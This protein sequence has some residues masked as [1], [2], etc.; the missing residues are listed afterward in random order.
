MLASLSVLSLD[1]EALS[2]HLAEAARRNPAITFRPPQFS[3]GTSQDFDAVSLLA[4]DK[5]SLLA[6]VSR[7]IDLTFSDREEHRIAMGFAAHLEPTGWLASG[8]ETIAAE[9]SVDPGRADLVLTRLQSIEPIGLFARSLGECLRLQ[10]ADQGIL[11]WDLDVLL[12]HLPMVGDKRFAELAELCD[13]HASDIPD[14]LRPLR[15]LDPK[16]GLRFAAVDPPVFPPDL[17]ARMVNGSW[18]VDLN[19]STLPTV[20]VH[21]ERVPTTGS[22]EACVFRK[23]ALAEARALV[24]SV[25]RRG[26]TLLRVGSVLVARQMAF[27]EHGRAHLHPLTLE[28][29]AAELNLHASTISRATSGRLIDTPR[30]ALPLKAFF[31]RAVTNADGTEG[32]QDAALEFVRETIRAENPAKPHSDEDIAAIAEKAGWMIARRT[33]AK[34]R[35]RLGLPASHRRRTAAA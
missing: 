18:Q 35:M 17:I 29:V 12:D 10:A 25:S 30:G 20:T 28:D 7:Q 21:P 14:I 33:V 11:A 3:R 15:Q 19:K 8:V 32:S 22:P 26:E 2:A 31:S 4:S 6:H 5:P 23:Q 24:S 27:L 9:L 16:P 1:N 34:Y 13:C